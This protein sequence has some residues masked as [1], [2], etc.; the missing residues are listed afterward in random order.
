MLREYAALN[1]ARILLQ[2]GEVLEARETLSEFTRVD[3]AEDL[4]WELPAPPAI[5]EGLA[6]DLLG[7]VARHAQRK[8]HDKGILPSKDLGREDLN[9]HHEAGQKA[10]ELSKQAHANHHTS[11]PDDAIASYG[12]A[13]KAHQA[14]IT[15]FQRATKVA[16]KAG[17]QDGAAYAQHALDVHTRHA[18]WAKKQGDMLKSHVHTTMKA[19]AAEKQKKDNDATKAAETRPKPQAGQ[20]PQ[21]WAAA[22]AQQ[23]FASMKQRGQQPPAAAHTGAP[24]QQAAPAQSYNPSPHA[25]PAPQHTAPAAGGTGYGPAP[26]TGGVITKHPAQSAVPQRIKRKKAVGGGNGYGP[27]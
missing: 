3:E 20:A 25:Q 6:S 12:S 1:D 7:T 11:D 2:R 5:E 4:E 9:K 19:G 26:G 22:A 23:H 13:Q 8:L 17:D 27:G 14:M 15:R 16:H 10:I 18:N 21:H 24:A